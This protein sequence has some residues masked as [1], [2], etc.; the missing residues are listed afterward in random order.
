M[1]QLAVRPRLI[2]EGSGS[3][4]SIDLSVEGVAIPFEAD[5]YI[6][7]EQ[8]DDDDVITTLQ[9][10]VDY[11]ISTPSI[12]PG[13]TVPA[14]LTRIDGDLPLNYTWV[15]YRQTPRN[16]SGDIIDGG[17]FAS[18]DI[19]AMV[20]HLAAM[21]QEL[22]DRVD[23]TVRS[24][25]FDILSEANAR[26][27][28]LEGHSGEAVLVNATSDGFDL[29][30]LAGIQLTA[31]ATTLPPGSE[32]TAEVTGTAPNFVVELGIPRGN[33]GA[34]GDG[35]GDMLAAN[36]LSD[37][38]DAAAA[39]ANIKQAASATAT[40][41]VE[42]ATDAEAAGGTDATRY[43][44]SAQL[45][46]VRV[47]VASAAT[48]NIGVAASNFVLISGTTTITSFG[49]GAPNGLWRDMTFSGTLTL[50]H[51]SLLI[52]PGE[53]NI[54]TANG[55][56]AYARNI[57]G[58]TWVVMHYTRSNGTPLVTATAAEVAAGTN[59]AKPV[60]PASLYATTTAIASAATCDIGAVASNW[61][62]ISGTTN[63][64]SFGVA[65]AGLWREIYFEGVLTLTHSATLNLPAGGSNIVT[66]AA[67]RAMAR[68]Q[69]GGT[70]IVTRYQRQTGQALV[71][72]SATGKLVNRGY[73]AYTTNADLNGNIPWDD[74]IPQNT[75]GTEILSVSITPA[76]TSNRIRARFFGW[77]SID[78]LGTAD[79]VHVAA[80]VFWSGSAN[81]LQV[82]HASDTEFSLSCETEFAPS[83]MSAITI[84]VRIGQPTGTIRLNGDA[85]L[86]ARRYGGASAATL[87]VEEIVP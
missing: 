54:P 83:T 82:A 1:T 67:D 74:T 44:T 16:Q 46:E 84:S 12:A 6:I 22:G 65:P 58:D 34:S 57:G 9:Q 36:N 40:G 48:C 64:T 79:Q 69:G 38:V 72:P 53:T 23:R 33:T 29:G 5:S 17:N 41:V 73:S 70:W 85:A 11:T 76:S 10:G 7:V 25:P 52:L 43:I 19:E 39:F 13:A 2:W 24:S 15:A 32:A 3:T 68:S 49:T 14:T 42:L 87:V 37:V 63:I 75:E 20:D 78:G 35:T 18:G 27:P 71:A 86:N 60:T 28:P 21:V 56:R 66:G 47:E 59:A 61:V 80:A 50:T 77:G 4:D 55:D 31:D 8:K 62:Y 51:S 30:S 81:A 45:H 26:L